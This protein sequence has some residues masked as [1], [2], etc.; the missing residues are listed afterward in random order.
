MLHC[1]PDSFRRK[2]IGLEGCTLPLCSGH[3]GSQWIRDELSS[4]NEATGNKLFWIRRNLIEVKLNIWTQET[5]NII[6]I[7][8]SQ[9]VHRNVVVAT[10]HSTELLWT[11]WQVFISA[12]AV[13]IWSKVYVTN[14]CGGGVREEIINKY[15]W[16]CPI[17]IP[18]SHTVP[19]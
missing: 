18:I 12:R 1:V 19:V 3:G 4:D 9:A 15:F 2:V 14:I 7:D 16:E 8:C 17:T 5:I 6:S 11:R 10:L 13:K